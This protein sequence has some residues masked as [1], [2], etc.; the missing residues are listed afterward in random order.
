MR[1]LRFVGLADDGSHVVVEATDGSDQFILPIDDKLRDAARSDLPRLN[2]R[3]VSPLPSALS[4]K[5]IQTRVRSGEDPEDVAA[6]YGI[7]V[8]RVLRFAYSVLQERAR[9][10]SEARRGRARRNGSDGNLVPFGEAVDERFAAHGIL[11]TAVGWDAIRTEDGEWHV[12]ARWRGGEADREAWWNFTLSTRT[13][14]PLDDTATEL[15]SDRPVQPIE[16]VRPQLRTVLPGERAVVSLPV[17]TPDDGFFDQEALDSRDQS[18]ARAPQISLAPQAI[19]P[20]PTAVRAATPV[21]QAAIP[22]D[23]RPDLIARLRAAESP[24]SQQGPDAPSPNASDHTD[25]ARMESTDTAAVALG[26]VPA[27]VPDFAPHSGATQ[28]DGAPQNGSAPGN[29]SAPKV[30]GRTTG[31]P[32]GLFG[33]REDPSA[34]VLPLAFGDDLVAD[35]SHDERARIPSWDDILLGVRPKHD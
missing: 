14:T 5:E 34:P 2:G 32:V 27:L 7:P 4:P 6:A 11:A 12:V 35:E 17:R 13:L 30:H 22:S 16:P 10:S 33:T 28:N 31:S 8:E 23:W 9:V 19:A 15:L 20:K 25:D 18:T 21:E 3:S 24:T 26:V 29:E 1:L